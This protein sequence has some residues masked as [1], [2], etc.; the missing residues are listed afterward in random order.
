MPMRL[1]KLRGQFPLGMPRA[2]RPPTGGGLSLTLGWGLLAGVAAGT[3]V[4]G[5]FGGVLGGAVGEVLGR[6]VF[7]FK[8][9]VGG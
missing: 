4:A 6:A 9:R 3:A 2:P 1:P 8:T 7:G 5:P